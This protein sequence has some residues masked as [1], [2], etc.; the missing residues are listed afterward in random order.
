MSSL[1]IKDSS[2]QISEKSNKSES[3]EDSK[4]KSVDKEETKVKK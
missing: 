3:E 4:G 1:G 2:F